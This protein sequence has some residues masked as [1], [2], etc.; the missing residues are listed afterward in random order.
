MRNDIFSDPL[1]RVLGDGGVCT[2]RSL[3]VG[4]SSAKLASG[5]PAVTQRNPVSTLPRP[6]N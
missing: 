1:H 5:H 4:A 6:K 3:W 2:G